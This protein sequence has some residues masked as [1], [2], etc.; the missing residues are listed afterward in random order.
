MRIGFNGLF[1][2]RA[3]GTGRYSRELLRAV[4]RLEAGDEAR[5]DDWH[6]ITLTGASAS[7]SGVP[8]VLEPLPRMV[9]R[10]ELSAPWLMGSENSAKLWFEQRGC[11]N[12]ARSAGADILHYPYFAAPLQCP[13]PFVVTVHDL[14]PLVLPEYRGSR[15]VRAY[16][17]LQ[18][19]AA[20]RA[21]LILT[22]SNASR[23][24]VV[25]YLEVPR[26]RVRVVP[27]GVDPDYQPADAEA[28][29]A[30]RRRH[31]LPE[32]FILYVGN[33]DV[34][35]N[36]ERL[37]LAYA[38]AR[39]GLGVTEP[40]V[41]G[42]NADRQGP[43]FPP[44]RPLVSQLGLR[45]HVRFIG[46]I[47]Q[48]EQPALYS[49][50]TLF[51]FPSRFEGFGLPVLEAMACGAVVA[52]STASSLPEVA[53]D[54]AIGFDPDDEQACADAIVRGLT[55]EEARRELRERGLARAATFTWERTAMATLRAYRD[56]LAG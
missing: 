14:I 21:S 26:Q 23:H 5:R 33:L 31:G 35:K 29:A 43:L 42:G 54:A 45:E 1:L 28:I 10:E 9:T 19:A 56:A 24:D 52:C 53:G 18:A 39:A 4:A 32:R 34:R 13:L 20:R 48:E 25:R 44:L 8:T 2:R 46:T 6:L 11:P 41:I 47:S 7:S 12:A 55:D 30:V 22:D 51:V 38:R 3:D 50:C 15:S 40:L 36:V 37:I 16:M 17:R 49:A 27:L